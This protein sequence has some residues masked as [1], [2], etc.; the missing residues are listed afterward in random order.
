MNSAL[1]NGSFVTQSPTHQYTKFTK[2]NKRKK[3]L[4]MFKWAFYTLLNNWDPVVYQSGV[5]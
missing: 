2:N 4:I 1:Y 3:K 5:F